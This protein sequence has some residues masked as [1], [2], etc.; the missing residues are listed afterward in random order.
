MTLKWIIWNPV[1]EAKTGKVT[2]Y[3]MKAVRKLKLETNR[4]VTRFS[5][6]HLYK[7]REIVFCRRRFSPNEKDFTKRLAVN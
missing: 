2:K 3:T 5:I 7:S 1:N 6:F 4:V